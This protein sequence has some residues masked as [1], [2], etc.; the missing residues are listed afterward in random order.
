MMLTP[1]ER[2]LVAHLVAD[3][4]LQNNWMA[5]NKESLRH[6]GAWVHASIY[7]LCVG[8]A[9][10]WMAGVAL[11]LIH[12]LIDTGVPVQWWIRHFKKCAGVPE[13]VHIAIWADQVIH[14]GAIATWIAFVPG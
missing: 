2:A 7:G 14:I 10:N 3:W 8:L 12:I 4:L 11:G 9:L 6:P 5:Q 1:F 13:A